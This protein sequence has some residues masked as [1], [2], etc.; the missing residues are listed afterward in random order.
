[1]P[2]SII[3]R[4]QAKRDIEECFVYIAED[5]LDVGVYFLVAVEDTL[6][7]I[8]QNPYIGSKKQVNSSKLKDVRMWRVKSYPNYLIFYLVNNESIEIIRMI[9]AKRDFT[10]IFE[11]E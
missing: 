2:L 8:A 3:K 1:M 11:D 6:E 10:I 4:P 7:I 5:N 9:H